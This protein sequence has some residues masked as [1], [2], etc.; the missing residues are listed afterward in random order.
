MEYVKCQH[1][2]RG[3]SHLWTLPLVRLLEIANQRIVPMRTDTPEVE[4]WIAQFDAVDQ[5]TARTLVQNIHFVGADE[6]RAHM[7]AILETVPDQVG[8]AVAL[9]AERRIP[10]RK[11]SPHA[12]YKWPRRRVRR[13]DGVALRPADPDRQQE[14]AIGSE[15][16]VSQL[17]SD[18]QNRQPNIFRVHPSMQDLR[19]R[20]PRKFVLVTDFIG[21]GDR[22]R[23]FLDAAWKVPTLVSWAS[24][25]LLNFQV[26]A[27]SATEDGLAAVRAHP[28][29]P[30][31]LT[32]RGCPTIDLLPNPTR[33]ALKSLSDSY[34]PGSPTAAETPLGY[35]GT[36]ALLAFAH[37]APNNTPLLLHKRSRT[38]C[39]L[40]PARTVP[41]TPD[42]ADADYAHDEALLAL[43]EY[44]P[45]LQSKPCGDILRRLSFLP[46]GIYP[47]ASVCPTLIFAAWWSEISLRP[48]VSFALSKGRF[49]ASRFATASSRPQRRG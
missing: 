17:I 7:T 40:F 19:Q 11:T 41:F 28:C 48:T 47:F 6:F 24:Y 10:G 5:D 21:S 3:A 34:C 45:W 16:I 9:F 44:T 15:G 12:L 30:E 37:G 46:C 42:Q 29:R 18:L 32:V 8:R 23:R 14:P 33:D 38:W 26:V 49:P 36:G 1:R 25:R 27:Y 20:R 39:P 13:A 22:V 35:G 31:I 4:Q 43:R 2:S